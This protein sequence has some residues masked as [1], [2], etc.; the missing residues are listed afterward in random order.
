MNGN[1]SPGT[2]DLSTEF[3]KTFWNELGD[4]IVDSFNE[5]FQNNKLLES[6]NMS[7]LSL[8]Y[9]KVTHQILKTIGQLA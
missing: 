8:I 6:H 7:V 4:L 3:Y 5:V 1:K 9:K 2:D